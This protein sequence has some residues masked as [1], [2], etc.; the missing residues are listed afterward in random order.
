MDVVKEVA[1]SIL[2]V[3]VVVVTPPMTVNEPPT[4]MDLLTPT[5]PD[6]KREPVVVEVESVVPDTEAVVDTIV[7]LVREEVTSDPE[8]AIDADVRACILNSGVVNDCAVIVCV[9]IE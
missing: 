4:F 1:F 9:L 2:L 5:P 8:F 3:S 7:P 6:I